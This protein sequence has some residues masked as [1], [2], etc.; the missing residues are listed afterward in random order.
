V[1]VFNA[2]MHGAKG[3]PWIG[4]TRAMSFW[5]LP[6]KLTPADCGALTAHVDVFRTW[7]GFAGAKLT[8]EI[9]SQVEGRS[10]LPLLEN[11]QTE[12]KDRT[13][14][15]HTGR[16][17]KGSDYNAAKLNN[18]AVRTS[19]Y[20]LVSEAAAAAK[21]K[22]A[23]NKGWQLFDVKSDP[24]EKTD[25]SAGNPEVVKEMLGSYDAWWDSLK[26]QIDLNEK[27]RGPKLNPFAEEYWKQFGGGPTPADY[28][29]MNPE[30]AFTFEKR[31]SKK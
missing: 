1:K 23:N 3:T 5:R 10:L 14:F 16:W 15:S 22:A 9:E 12:W 19:R 30:K 24:G 18:A 7:A 8:P 25:I 20:H 31:R 29:R 26:G 11:P 2:G 27:A 17:P 21:A 13:L 28:E 6:G 4:G